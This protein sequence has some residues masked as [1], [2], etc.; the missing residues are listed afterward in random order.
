V[1]ISTLP[2]EKIDVQLK[3]FHDKRKIDVVVVVV[4]VLY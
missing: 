3:Y 4:V 1:I 2:N